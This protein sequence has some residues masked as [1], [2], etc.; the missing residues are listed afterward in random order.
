MN[1]LPGSYRSRPL[2]VLAPRGSDLT[3][4]ADA[5]VNK[6]LYDEALAGVQRFRGGVYLGEGNLTSSNLSPDG[7]HIQAADHK[8]WHLL[9]LDQTGEVQACGRVFIHEDGVCFD[10]L[11]ASHSALARSEVW[12]QPLRRSV[13]SEI[14]IARRRGFRFGELGGWAVAR[15]MRCTTEAVRLVLACYA[16]GQ[17]LG[18]VMG[19]GTV[20]IRHHSSSILRRLGGRP[21][22]MHGTELPNY[23][24]PLYRSELEI[25]RFDSSTPNPRYAWSIE[26]C[27]AWFRQVPVIC[28]E[29]TGAWKTSL[30]Q[31]NTAL[32]SLATANRNRIETSQALL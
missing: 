3:P 13:E 18:G 4:F 17:L 6:Y 1:L 16:F 26:Q 7:R 27:R 11:T 23:Y 12:G 10:D 19:I 14:R 29:A 8:S 32:A 25:L 5:A 30:V 9:T 2:I 22:T 21:L 28:G 15:G 24:E 31:L 20:G